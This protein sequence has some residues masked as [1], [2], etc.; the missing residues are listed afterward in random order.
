MMI[1][2]ELAREIEAE[3]LEVLF[4]M[5][6][7][8]V[9][10]WAEHREKLFKAFMK[11]ARRFADFAEQLPT[12]Y[13]GVMMHQFVAAKTF[14]S[15]IKLKKFL[16]QSKGILKPHEKEKIDFFF[17]HPW[18]FSV[19]SIEE[20]LQDD[21]LR[22]YDYSLE[23]SLVLHSKE[24]HEFSRAGDKLF[25]CLLFFN[26][27]CYQN[28]GIINAFKGITINDIRFFARNAGPRFKKNSDLSTAIFYNPLPF[29]FLCTFSEQN[30][31]ME[32]G[33][34]VEYLHH[35]M[36]VEDFQ[37]DRY[38]SSFEI[39]E[40]NKVLKLTP[41]TDVDF[42][43][44][45]YFIYEPK[46]RTLH[47]FTNSRDLYLSL[48]DTISD[49]YDFPEEPLFQTSPFV[50]P[51]IER[52]LGVQPPVIKFEKMFG[53]G[54]PNPEVQERLSALNA[55]IGD[56]AEIYHHGG[57]LSLDDLR[58]DHGLSEEEARLIQKSIGEIE[59][60]FHI[61]IEGGFKD[62]TPPAPIER[63]QFSEPFST[64]S[65]F[66]FND[67]HK[68]VKYLKEK[69][70]ELREDMKDLE[71]QTLTLKQLP[72]FL[73]DLNYDNWHMDTSIILVYTI[74]LLS[75]K[76]QDFLKVHDY[77]VEFLKLF[78][79]IILPSNDKKSIDQFK[80]NYGYFC[81]DVLYRTGLIEADRELDKKKSR[82]SNYKIRAA[83]FFH[84]WITFKKAH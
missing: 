61:D 66:R 53:G 77:A 49:N 9:Y 1:D 40:K 29:M 72:D 50:Y 71:Y 60:K 42:E 30:V 17:E 62:F 83:P 59:R 33:N 25:L 44:T 11:E 69:L 22:I 80:K 38:A 8:L 3:N 10:E 14:G 46:K 54:K 52:I 39:Q 28:F 67:S 48:K 51:A 76:G 2:Y 34:A 37:P 81:Y 41:K 55:A 78:W 4:P 79:Q 47:L 5:I 65:L 6:D 13:L 15:N 7:E 18:F 26:G 75:K 35:S 20:V 70:P 24:V 63:I 12:E 68:A 84:E 56:A 16:N 19:F 27:E 73:E 45:G 31:T 23:Q 74:F 32:E 64:S 57:Q 43:N 82:Q 21:F 58:R 36:T